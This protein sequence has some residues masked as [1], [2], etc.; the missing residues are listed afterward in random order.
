MIG[1][2]APDAVSSPDL[3]ENLG[4][5]GFIIWDSVGEADL[6]LAG[7]TGRALREALAW[8]GRGPTLKDLRATDLSSGSSSLARVDLVGS[9]CGGGR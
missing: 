2:T 5:R 4:G 8:S 3:R 9:L 1:W 6:R 7:Y